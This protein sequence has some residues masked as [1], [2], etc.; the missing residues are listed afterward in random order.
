MVR[1]IVFDLDGTLIDS[2]RDIADAAN[3]L[4]ESCGAPP[5]PEAVIGR[6]VGEGAA[7]LVARAFTA[8]AI[9]EPPDAL[10]RFLELYETRWLQHTVPYPGVPGVLEALGR[11]LPLAVL[12]NKPLRATRHILQGL[13]LAR[14]FSS[15]AV[16]GGDGP[17]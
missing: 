5:L 14:H 12:T 11:R 1:L 7:L 8:A 6:M 3:A 17:V 16:I 13:D 15:D 2:R 9:P 10:A 4:I